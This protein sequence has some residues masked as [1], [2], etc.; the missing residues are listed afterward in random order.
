MADKINNLYLCAGGSMAILLE[1]V[2]PCTILL[3]WRWWN[4][5]MIHYLHT[6]AKSFT[7]RLSFRILQH[8][9]YTLTLSMHTG[10]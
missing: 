1:K 5:I 6:T 7:E 9:N 2:D 10:F 8:G 4:D 3:L